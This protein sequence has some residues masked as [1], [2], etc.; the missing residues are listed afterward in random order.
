M[1]VAV[2]VALK[3]RN[4][5]FAALDLPQDLRDELAGRAVEVAAALGGRA[6]PAANLHLTLAFLGQVPVERGAAVLEALQES[7]LPSPPPLRVRLG[8]LTPRPSRGRARL[9]AAGL[10]EPSGELEALG[11]RVQRALAGLGFA[12]EVRERFWPHVTVVRFPRPLAVGSPVWPED[13][14]QFDVSRATLY[15]SLLSSGGPPRY[16]ALWRAEL[17]I[18]Q[19]I[20][21]SA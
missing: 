6:V 19:A 21:Q 2:D 11:L 16:E 17:A 7:L 5:L 12:V 8:P 1:I 13:E 9:L 14:R 18:P 20:T 15:D 4:R 3:P 10:A